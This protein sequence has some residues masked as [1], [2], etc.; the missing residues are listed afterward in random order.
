M[1][2]TLNDWLIDSPLSLCL[3]VIVQVTIVAAIASW[4]A[5]H[6]KGFDPG[7]THGVWLTAAALTLLLLP[8]HVVVGG[9][10]IPLKAPQNDTIASSV[11][12]ARAVRNNDALATTASADLA[13]PVAMRESIDPVAEPRPDELLLSVSTPMAP[14]ANATGPVEPQPQRRLSVTDSGLV[15]AIQTSQVQLLLVWIYAV[16]FTWVALRM[17]AGLVRL[18][19]AAMRGRA[20]SASTSGIADQIRGVLD[21]P[22]TPPIRRT[23]QTSMPLVF[24]LLRPTVLVPDDFDCWSE[25]EIR[26]T[27]LHELM[28]VRR[29]DALGQTLASINLMVYWFHPAVW[30]VDRRLS[31][32][33]EWA[34]DRDVLAAS[35]ASGGELNSGRYAES[36]LNIVARF[37][38]ADAARRL[39]ER[40]AIAMSRHSE[41]EDRLKLILRGVP[42]LS[43]W[44]I[45]SLRMMVALLAVAAIATTVRLDRS[46]AQETSDKD[47]NPSATASVHAETDDAPPLIEPV[48]P[49][50]NDLIAR[51]LTCR[52]IMGESED[53]AVIVNVSGKV[54][55]PD[56]QP[57]PSA[58][59]V[60]RESSN[61]RASSNFNK[62]L[63]SVDRNQVRVPDVIARTETNANGEFEFTNIKAPAFPRDRSDRW[64]GSLVAAMPGVGVATSKLIL[65][66][67]NPTPIE[68][69][70]LQLTKTNSISGRFVTPDGRPLAGAIVNLTGL[71]EPTA[72][73]WDAPERIELWM[74][75][76]TPRTTTDD[77]GN[78]DFQN[79]PTGL[80]AS[81]QA[82][83]PDWE[84]GYA[85]VRTSD[86]VA[87]G[88]FARANH[89]LPSGEVVASPA[90]VVADPGYTLYGRVR[91]ARDAAIAGISIY[92]SSSVDR[93][94]T[95]SEGHFRMRV[96]TSMVSRYLERDDP[97]K[98]SVV[99]SEESPFLGTQLELTPGQLTGQDSIDVTLSDAVTISGKVVDST[100]SPLEG[101][102]IRSLNLPSPLGALSKED[103]T[104]QLKL[105]VGD[106]FLIVATLDSGYAIP[107]FAEV[108]GM[109]KQR[110]ESL[111][112]RRIAIT[113]LTPRTIKPIVVPKLATYQ[114]IV[115]LPDGNPAVGASVILRD[116]IPP[117]P[118]A[119]VF[120]QAPHVVDRSASESTNSLGRAAL[121]PNGLTSPKAFVDVKYLRDDDAFSGTAK[122]IEA[123][124]GVI[125]L[126]L[127]SSAIV[128]GRVLVDG[129]P[130]AG[131]RVQISL[132][133]SV[134][135]KANG[136]TM[137]VHQ[138]LGHQF[139]TTDSEGV[140]RA[141]VPAGGN[142][143]TSLNNAPNLS[144]RMGI[145]YGA[146]PAG[147]GK[148]IVQ[149]FELIRG[150]QEIAGR[151]IDADGNPVAKAMVSVDRDS[152]VVPDLWVDHHRESQWTT[153]ANGRFHLKNVPQ[154]K[155]Q[156]SVR[157]PQGESSVSAT[158]ISTLVPVRTGE[159]DLEITLNLPN[160]PE[161]PRLVPIEVTPKR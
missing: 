69:L 110:A 113:D 154:G 50:D 86:E 87:V 112:H 101:I 127:N 51:V 104:F 151:V 48:R 42:G 103:G 66:K 85:A 10:R 34:T 1:S 157:G 53:Y 43:R 9:W 121:V 41:I 146:Q 136:M 98:F 20:V 148:L 149:D 68:G 75:Q 47:A 2:E 141:C 59:V 4:I 31:E 49:E 63:L 90:A 124:D 40:S 133:K 7:R 35:S 92:P 156:L 3:V 144:F 96:P 125:H 128:Q 55:S 137:M 131:A 61:T 120:D 143:H 115:S 5:A 102:L 13:E 140:Y 12:A 72:D 23:D 60:L 123:K 91:D 15:S 56:G 139:V 147:D 71:F 54:L 22:G 64:V 135:R 94:K 126:V 24:G 29:R 74:S 158:R 73:P 76:L 159:T 155:Y 160:L 97:M 138:S 70:A 107:S 82:S 84:N 88:K 79:I 16:G 80:I 8:V 36:L 114:V 19:I 67:S 95:D 117:G 81:I 18:R 122:L 44:R 37:R 106:H 65:E 26:S 99:P 14:A 108:I 93:S 152:N 83:H 46:A 27:L 105:S 39:P 161:I 100:G 17:V 132:T 6:I 134:Q 89:W 11:Q 25:D 57:V 38:V 32:S 109:T 119:P 118:N 116:E 78:F 33:R 21:L 129:E 153:D 145:G 45:A 30:L 62:Y 58:V 150:K 130:V 111:P 28:H 52:P 77:S 142:V